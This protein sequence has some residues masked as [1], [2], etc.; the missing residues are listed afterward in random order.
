MTP[1]IT[2]GF[3]RPYAS[4]PLSFHLLLHS[5]LSLSPF[6]FSHLI[7]SSTL[8]L[9]AQSPALV[10]IL[11]INVERRF[12]GNHLSADSFLVH[13][14]SQ[15]IRMNIKYNY[16]QGYP[17]QRTFIPSLW[18]VV[19]WI[20]KT[21]TSYFWGFHERFRVLRRKH[22]PETNLKVVF[23]YIGCNKEVGGG[24]GMTT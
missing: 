10:F 16:P 11:Q 5:P 24:T 1:L 15:E 18:Q 22:S 8:P 9:S 13:S 4:A 14:H 12:T 23:G 2:Y 20:C 21:K 19:Y 3:S 17:Q 7:F 6:S